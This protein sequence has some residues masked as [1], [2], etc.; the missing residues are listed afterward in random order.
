[1]DTDGDWAA[2]DKIESNCM[3]VHLTALSIS[4]DTALYF[5]DHASPWLC[6]LQMLQM[7]AC[8]DLSGTDGV[9]FLC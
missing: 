8:S 5:H 4:A 2:S 9:M 6:C 3:H 7:E 1:M